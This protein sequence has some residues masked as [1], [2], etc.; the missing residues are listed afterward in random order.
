MKRWLMIICMVLLLPICAS[1][2][3]RTED[4]YAPSGNFTRRHYLF[5]EELPAQLVQP[6]ADWGYGH[7]HILSGAA[8][9]E[10]GD[11][12]RMEHEPGSFP[13]FSALML[14]ENQGETQLIGAA[15]VEGQPWQVINFGTKLLRSTTNVSM[16][17]V[18]RPGFDRPGLAVCYWE[19]KKQLD[20]FCFS[21][22]RLWEM[23]GHRTDDLSISTAGVFTSF[24][25]RGGQKSE[26]ARSRSFWMEYMN[27]ID[28]YPTTQE[29]CMLLQPPFDE[30]AWHYT[31]GA[32][33]RSEPSQYS[34]SLGMYRMDV[35]L[36]FYGEYES[37][38]EWPWCRV[39]IGNTEGWMSEQYVRPGLPSPM[40]ALTVG[41]TLHGCT[42]LQKYR[43]PSSAV[44]L[45]PGTQF[46]ILAE[47]DDGWRHICIPSGE[48][49]AEMDINGTY[50]YVHKDDMITGASVITLDA[51]ERE[52]SDQ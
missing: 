2:A 26:Y 52:Y 14:V 51:L 25:D 43:D 7:V 44:Q 36:L 8:I 42:M 18:D 29:A 4:Q 33:L 37:G 27:S 35:P 21:G 40:A 15:W 6:M 10:P 46:H 28:E 20:L 39:R 48:L 38:K 24:I 1:A 32:N 41:R 23:I 11:Q 9:E 34:E 50:G 5:E 30:G 49:V 47:T 17:I 31:T 12:L 22:N 45:A 19:G 13:S 16:D 3:V